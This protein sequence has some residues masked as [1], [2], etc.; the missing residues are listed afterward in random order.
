M[1]ASGGPAAVAKVLNLTAGALEKA[2]LD[3]ISERSPEIADQIKKHMFVFED[4]TLLDNRS[5]QRLLRD[6]DSKELALSM[7]AASDGL[8]QLILSNMSERAAGALKEEI[9]FLG[10]VRVRDVEGAHSRIIEV[11]RR[12]EE[13]G[14]IVISGREADD[15][16][17]S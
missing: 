11:V 14:D 6:I 12:L 4:L 8:K 10:P 16:I 7:K 17:I 15:D 5:M 9:E 3:G 1:T 13:S 2:L